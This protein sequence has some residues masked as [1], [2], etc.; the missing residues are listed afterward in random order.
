MPESAISLQISFGDSPLTARL[1]TSE[2]Y[3]D[4]H[5]LATRFQNARRTGPGSVELPIDD[6]LANLVELA[7]WP[8]PESVSWDPDLAELARTTTR[9]AQ[10][11]ASRLETFPSFDQNSVDILHVEDELG[12]NW[13]GNITAFQRR[14]VAHL[15]SLRHGANF[16]VPGAGKTRVA[17]A[18]FSALKHKGEVEQ[19]LIIGPKSSYESWITENL[20]CLDP[21]LRLEIFDGK[22]S[23]A[24]NG[25]I[26]NYE[27]LR[28]STNMLARWLT[29]KSTLL[30]LDEAHRMKL[31]ADGVYGSACMALGTRARRRII[32][33]GTPAPNGARD[34]ENLMAFVWPGHGRQIVNR[35]VA[36]GNLAHASQV[37]RP[38]FTRTTKAELGLPPM[39]LTQR[40]VEMPPLHREIYEGL[41]GMYSA[42]AAACQDDLQAL[43]KIFIYLL[44]A[45]ISPAL[46]TTGAT[47]HEPLAYRVPPLPIPNGSNLIELMR[48]LPSYELSP[49]YT[50]AL[51]VIAYNASHGRKTIV[52][53]SF[54][55]SLNTL[56][57]ILQGYNPALVHGGTDNREEEIR[58]FRLDPDCMVLLSNPATLGEGISLHHECHDAVYIDRDFA[59][60]RF[61]QSLDRIHRL[62]LSADTETRAVV[63][64]TKNTIDEVVNQRLGIKLEFMGRILD[65][66][67]VH[68]LA[69]LAEEPS[70]V[71]GLDPT[72]VQDLMRHLRANPA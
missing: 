18:V 15:L 14:D 2:S 68:E 19:I 9:D 24:T 1:S 3:D 54:I 70:T 32:L 49:K 52:W 45:A 41:V 72:D 25:V 69:D 26:I 71:G 60:G 11:M 6:L 46:L 38:L 43:G 22:I 36:G 57:N 42:R 31:G 7:A 65:D 5:R 67:S 58:R 47:A 37:L 50:E 29:S 28:N 44:M 21:P 4:L 16:S 66:P 13:R 33:T 53:S 63:L 55:R 62:G 17:L 39:T 8:Y 51:N 20:Q 34:L 23:P 10:D 59:A 27:R 61:L 48:D 40:T 56:A 35:A 12:P 64:T 30:L